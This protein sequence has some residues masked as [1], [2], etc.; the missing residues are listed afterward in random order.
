MAEILGV[1]ANGISIGSLA[2]QLVESLQ[3]IHRFWKLV[4]GAPKDIGNTIE[5]L[6]ILASIFND[7]LDQPQSSHRLLPSNSVQVCFQHCCKVIDDLKPIVE[8]LHTDLLGNKCQKQWASIKSALR[9]EDLRDL[10]QRLERSKST[11]ELAIDSYK[12]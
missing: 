10:T 3:K 1:I 7:L 4:D 12:L 6:Q 8:K 5:E 9:K 2:I 11:L